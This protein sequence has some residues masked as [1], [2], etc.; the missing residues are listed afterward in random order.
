MLHNEIKKYAF[1]FIWIQ[2]S[3]KGNSNYL[4]ITNPKLDYVMK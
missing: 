4:N 3:L 1:K 2:V